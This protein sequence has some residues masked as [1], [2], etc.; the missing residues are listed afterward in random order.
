MLIDY[1][2]KLL[3]CFTRHNNRPPSRGLRALPIY[4]KYP[5]PRTRGYQA[6]EPQQ[7]PA[8]AQPCPFY[9][10]IYLLKNLF[11]YLFI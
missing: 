5:Q 4:Y 7:L 11:I 1:S 2:I 10:F 6:F 8:I 3:N 9:L